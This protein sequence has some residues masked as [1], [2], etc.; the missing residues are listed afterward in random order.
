MGRQRRAIDFLRQRVDT[1]GQ[2]DEAEATRA[3]F[4]ICNTGAG[5]NTMFWKNGLEALV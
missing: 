4:R 3:E 5:L 2:S 1:L